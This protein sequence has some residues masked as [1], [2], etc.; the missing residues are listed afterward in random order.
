MEDGGE[1]VGHA[2]LGD[3]SA[4]SPCG[5]DEHHHGLAALERRVQFDEALLGGQG[6]G[7]G[8]A[9]VSNLHG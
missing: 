2:A 4:V 5:A 6:R 7:Y 1:V 9:P 3:E 8:G